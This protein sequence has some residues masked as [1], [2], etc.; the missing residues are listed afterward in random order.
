MGFEIIEDTTITRQSILE[1]AKPRICGDH[2][3]QYGSL[4]NS[5]KVIAGRWREY[6]ISRGAIFFTGEGF[7]STD[8]A[9]M[10]VLFKCAQIVIGQNKTDN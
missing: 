6:F 5:F 9:A 8:V 7:N 2:D 10:M 3:Q 1:E 4:E